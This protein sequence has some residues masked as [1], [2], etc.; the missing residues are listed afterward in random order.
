MRIIL[1]LLAAVLLPGCGGTRLSSDGFVR[2]G[3]GIC[4]DLKRQIADLDPS[5]R[6][7]ME[8]AE[9][10]NRE[11]VLSFRALNVAPEIRSTLNQMLAHIEQAAKASK[12]AFAAAERGDARALRNARRGIDRSRAAYRRIALR[13]G[14]T[15]CA[16]PDPK[17]TVSSKR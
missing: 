5:E 7:F 6:T 12:T 14:L 9:R 13:L 8:D 17:P 16:A 3:N 15:D 2:A 11:G 1:V 10:I 4:K